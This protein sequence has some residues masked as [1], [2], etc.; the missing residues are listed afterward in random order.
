MLQQLAERLLAGVG[1]EKVL[2]EWLE[3]GLEREQVVR[4]VVDEEDVGHQA[5]VT[6]LT[7]AGCT[8]SP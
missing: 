2:L 1:V 8:Q 4:T 6:S 5:F 3:D 7:V